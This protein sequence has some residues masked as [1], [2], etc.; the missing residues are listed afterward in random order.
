MAISLRITYRRSLEGHNPGQFERIRPRRARVLP[1]STVMVVVIVCLNLDR[2]DR[3]RLTGSSG[4][5]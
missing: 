5:I 2:L 1:L 3:L 4:V